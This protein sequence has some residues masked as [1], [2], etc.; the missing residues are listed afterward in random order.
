MISVIIPTLNEGSGIGVLLSQL[1]R[2]RDI[3]LEIIVV[4]GESKDETKKTVMAAGA[5]LLEAET[6]RGVQ[7][8]K[9]AS[10][11]KGDY[12]LFLHA[13]SRLTND[14][15]L[16]KAVRM[17]EAES[18]NVAGHF[19]MSFDTTDWRLKRNLRFYEIKAS[20]NRP[21]SWNG[22]QGLLILASTFR[23]SGGFWERLPF[24]E[25]QDFGERFYGKGRFVTFNSVLSTSARRF[26][27]GGFRER[28]LINAIIMT[29]FHLCL[30]DF[31]T[32]AVNIYGNDRQSVYVEPLPYLMIAK[33]LLFRGKVSTVLKRL[34]QLGQ[35]A[36]ENLWQLALLR[37]IYR[38]RV[39]EHLRL[40]D[41]KLRC[42]VQ[43]PAGYIILMIVTIAWINITSLRLR[44]T[45]KQAAS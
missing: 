35:Y 26:E 32:Q 18:G 28:V 6:G 22:D 12:L 19:K 5:K 38:G 2:Q 27:Q 4:D 11:A 1:A 33:R 30:D 9:G 15:Q 24:L 31:F 40:Y 45:C 16:A 44:K 3:T 7:M 34:Y 37:G 10:A 13:D 42:L 20:L 43:N 14:Y 29:M 21:G 25:D 36:C 23:E 41:Q 17:L 39:D 8:N